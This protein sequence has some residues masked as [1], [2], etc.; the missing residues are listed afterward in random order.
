MGSLGLKDRDHGWLIV[1]QWPEI[2]GS[3]VARRSHAVR[4]DD[5]VLY[6]AVSDA[7]W[8]QELAMQVEN[9]LKEIHSLPHGRII[10]KLRLIHGMKGM[11]QS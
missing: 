3:H 10:K 8:R 9:I 7:V 11:S 2:V 4:Y 5:G 6:V 1:Q